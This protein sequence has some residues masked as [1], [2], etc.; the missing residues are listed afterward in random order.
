MLS[1]GGVQ[2]SPVMPLAAVPSVASP[3]VSPAAAQSEQSTSNSAPHYVSAPG[4]QSVP[5]TQNPSAVDGAMATLGAGSEVAPQMAV[6]SAAGSSTDQTSTGSGPGGIGA[7]SAGNPSSSTGSL[8]R[9]S[10]HQFGRCDRYRSIDA[11]QPVASR[12]EHVCGR[13]RARRNRSCLAGAR[14]GGGVRRATRRRRRSESPQRRRAPAPII[15]TAPKATTLTGGD[16]PPP[17]AAPVAPLSPVAPPISSDL[18]NE[19]RDQV[20]QEFARPQPPPAVNEKGI[21]NL[22]Q[23]MTD[24]PVSLAEPRR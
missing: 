9:G 4:S 10:E 3:S 24:P 1:A 8:R 7:V 18:S 16:V 11:H 20:L 15:N 2:M 23:D 13:R 14:S 5:V 6:L 19:A 12:S 22:L 17:A 21:D